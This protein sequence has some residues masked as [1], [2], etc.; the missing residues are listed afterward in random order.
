MTPDELQLYLTKTREAMNAENI[1][2][3]YQERVMNRL[4]YGHPEGFRREPDPDEKVSL[5]PF[6][7]TTAG[8]WI[9]T[10]EEQAVYKS[11]HPFPVEPQPLAPVFGND[12]REVAP[13][14]MGDKDVHPL[15]SSCRCGNQI[16]RHVPEESSWEHC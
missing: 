7:G 2:G 10:D 12:F 6:D 8:G 11:L 9:G 4:L 3:Y 13:E 16:L 1:T 14:Q 15:L 5:A